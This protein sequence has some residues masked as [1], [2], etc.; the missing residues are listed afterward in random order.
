MS[1]YEVPDPILNSPFE[2]PAWHWDLKEGEAPQKRAGRRPAGYFYRDPKAPTGTDEHTARGV[3]EELKLVNRIRERLQEWRTLALR[4]EGGVTRTTQ[5]LL[6]YWRREG[7]QHRLFFAQLEAAETIIFLTEARMDFKQGIEIPLDE[8][9]TERQAEGYRAFQ[10]Q[11]L[12]MATGAGKTTVMGMLAAWSILNKVND[13][14]DGRFSDTVLVVCPSVTIRNRLQELDP[15]HGEA[16]LYRTRDLVPLHLMPDLNKGRIVVTNWHVFEPQSPQAGGVSARVNRA[17]VQIQKKEFIRIGAKTTTARG[18]RYLTLEELQ[19][20]IDAGLL[21]VL[22][23]EHD[24]QGN[25]ERVQVE[26]FRYI[27]SDHALVN[28]VLGREVG[29]KQNILVFNDE[30][31]HAYRIRRPEPE[32]DEDDIFGE[33]EEREEF[34]KEATVWVEGLDKIHKLRGINFCVDLSATPYFLGRVGQDTNRTF[35]W[36]VSDFGLTDAIESGLVKIPQLAVRDTTGAE[37]PGYFNIWHWIL[38][39]LTASERGAKKSS[40]KPEAILKYANTPIAMLGGLWEQLRKA[41][42]QRHN[43]PRPPVFILVCKNTRIAKVMYEWLAEDKRPEGIPKI[44][45]EG[46]R[47]QNCKVVTIRV[48]SKVVNETDTGEAK[49]DEGKW[50]RLTL[51]TVGKTDWPRDRQG[52]TI[53]PEGFEELAKKLSRPFHPPGRDVRCIVSVGMLTEGWDCNTVTHIVGLRPFM[54]QLLCEQVVGRGLRRTSYEVGED[55][56]LGEEVAKI[57]GVPFEIIPFKANAT[58]KATPPPKRHHI[59]AIPEKAQFEIQFPRVT[60]YRQAIRNRVT[61]NWET[62]AHLVLDP[63]KIPPEVQMKAAIPNNQGRPSLTGPGKLENIDLNPYRS[64]RRLQELVFELAGDLTRDYC[65]Q[66]RSEVPAHVLFPQLVKVVERYVSEKVQVVA[67]GQLMDVFLSPYYGWVIERLKNEIH[68][69]TSQGEAPEL[70]VYE[71]NRGPGT[72]AEVNFWTSRDVREVVHSHLNYVVAD[73][74]QWEQ[75]AA[76]VIDNHPVVA[77]FVKNAGLGFA[78]P[79]LHNGQMHDYVPDFI[80][81]LKSESPHYLILETKGYDEL[82]GIKEQAAQ[83]WVNAVNA[84]G[85]YGRWEYAIARK[86]GEV[87]ERIEKQRLFL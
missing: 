64:G 67:P 76:Y 75:S 28:R 74:K 59:H 45:I 18:Q 83:R 6:N 29:N 56:K 49:N 63:L 9:S 31:H 54:S 15:A 57:F 2:E 53:F 17:G 23:E 27:E 5:E 51:D 61:I 43:D 30:A 20:Q 37:I 25:L 16:S 81:R 4:G 39:K 62:V 7:R 84:D 70:P 46:F 19:R 77:A 48:D 22:D 42:E 41:W 68:P 8:P 36:V 50:M 71:T 73:T 66:G 3:W 10:R 87:K 80:I 38:P 21:T 32:E 12:K 26:S 79:Y 11:A 82:A 24:K 13:R 60:G 34:F 65:S 85:C 78:I 35:P 58:G 69:D 52:R 55:G 44:G 86:P 47:N 72:T 1:G 14:S 40:P 33:D